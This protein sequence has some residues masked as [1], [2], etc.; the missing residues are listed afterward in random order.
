MHFFKGQIRKKCNYV[1]D[2]ENYRKNLNPKNNQQFCL[3]V[4]FLR[5]GAEKN[6]AQVNFKIL[7][8]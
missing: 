8:F 3:S 6:D 7:T 4:S 1:Y 5:R 2:S